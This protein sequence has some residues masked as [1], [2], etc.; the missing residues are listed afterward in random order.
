MDEFLP[1][2]T[3]ESFISLYQEVFQENID[4]VL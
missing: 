1:H 2:I 3:Q 4:D